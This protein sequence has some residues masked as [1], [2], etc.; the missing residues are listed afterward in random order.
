METRPQ[1]DRITLKIDG[2]EISCQRGKTL[3]QVCR[4]SKINIPTLCYDDRLAPFGGCRLCLV[5]IKGMRKPVASCTTPV[6]NGMEITTESEILTRHRKLVL[7][8]ILSNHPNDCMLCE[9]SG[10]CGLQDL[11]YRYGVT[12]DKY[13]GERWNLPKQED[14]PFISFDPNKCVMCGR[15]VN[16]CQ[17]LVMAGTID[18]TGRGFHSKPD[19][20]FS[21]PRT[22]D[23]CTFCGQCI[24]ACPVGALVEK[25][26][27]GKGRSY[28]MRKVKTT[29]TYCGTG[30][31]FYLNVKD[32]KVLKV[33]S[34]FDAPVNQGNLCIKGRFA[35]EFIHHPDR[36]TTPLIR[37]G[38]GFRKASWEE[39]LNLVA[40]RFK[41]IMGSHGPDAVGA[42]SSSRCTNE[43]NFL[44][45]KWVRAVLGSNNVDNCAR[46]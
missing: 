32:D 1:D 8:L 9:K 25:P 14:N 22:P 3:L 36:I 45:S 42:F 27:M 43:E 11:A 40:I 16:I 34:D 4:E 35:Y 41:E 15:C 24:S 23:I 7:S 33:T 13:T 2:R 21:R 44:I 26:S 18:F 5:E 30:C 31:N 20:A 39:A 6:E 19:T 28:E 46:V 17:D 12:G 10:D 29:C 38:D 37:E